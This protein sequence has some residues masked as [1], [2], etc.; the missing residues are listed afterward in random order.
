MFDLDDI[1]DDK[2]R[3]VNSLSEAFTSS[4]NSDLLNASRTDK[5][6]Q[7]LF[8][9]PVVLCL[10]SHDKRDG[11]I[12][13]DTV[14]PTYGWLLYCLDYYIDCSKNQQEDEGAIRNGFFDQFVKRSN[15]G[16][17]LYIATEST[18]YC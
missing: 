18:I 15:L 16:N 3:D 17:T 11:T 14:D 2:L 6:L 7:L 1:T 9:G 10:N 4:K 12:N 8:F 13:G 5:L